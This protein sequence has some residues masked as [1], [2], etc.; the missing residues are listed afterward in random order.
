MIEFQP[1]HD[2]ILVKRDDPHEVS[3]GG[4]LLPQNAQDVPVKGTVVAVG[5]GRKNPNGTITSL[6]VKE[7]DRILF[8][9]FSGSM[10]KLEAGDEKEFLVL[11]ED[12]VM[13]I[14]GSNEPDIVFGDNQIPDE[15]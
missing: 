5:R 11:R 13:G 1:L 3:K 12:E 2:R 6:D 7:G 4:I 9:K 10:V 8:G 14:F 15:E